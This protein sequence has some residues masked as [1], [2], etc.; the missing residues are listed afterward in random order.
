VVSEVF[1]FPDTLSEVCPIG[2]SIRELLLIH[3]QDGINALENSLSATTIEE[4]RV[5]IEAHINRK[6]DLPA[7]VAWYKENGFV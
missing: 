4:L 5:E 3:L 1:K 7:I 2:G 6:I